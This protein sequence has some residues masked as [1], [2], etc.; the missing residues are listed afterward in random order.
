M[1]GMYAVNPDAG[2]EDR[3]TLTVKGLLSLGG[4]RPMWP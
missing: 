4:S 1:E 3:N 2:V